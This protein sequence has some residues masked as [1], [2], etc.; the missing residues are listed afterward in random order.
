MINCRRIILA[1][2]VANLRIFGIIYAKFVYCGKRAFVM[3]NY[4]ILLLAAAVLFGCEKGPEQLTYSTVVTNT[5]CNKATRAETDEDSNPFLVLKYT[6]NGLE[7]TRY[8]ALLNCAINNGGIICDVS[9]EGNVI[10]YHAYEKDGTMLKCMCPVDRMSSV[11][12]G[13][14]LGKEYV[15]EYKCGEDRASIGFVYSNDLNEV[16]PLN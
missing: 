10:S 9:I 1:F 13:L 14:R 5:G 15:L 2:Q 3:K 16:F 4:L 8:N 7:L 11:I 6:S 12:G